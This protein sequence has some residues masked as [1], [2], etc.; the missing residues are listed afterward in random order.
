MPVKFFTI[1]LFFN[2]AVYSSQGQLNSGIRVSAGKEKT[3]VL[4]G[5]VVNLPFFIENN[6]ESS[7]PL[8]VH[9]KVPENWKIISQAQNFF[10]NPGERKFLIVT[11]QIPS[12]YPMG[13]FRATL[14]AVHSQTGNNLDSFT[15]HISVG[16]VEKINL[17]LVESPD[18]ISAGEEF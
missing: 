6:S 15:V 5:Q 8:D 9:L 10:L 11:V 13:E 3:E 12:N 7:C 16:E 14:N 2:Y 1:L 4:P 17:I 18:Y